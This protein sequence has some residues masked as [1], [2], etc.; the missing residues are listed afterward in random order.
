MEI[1]LHPSTG[2]LEMRLNGR[3]DAAWADYVSETLEDAVRAGSHQITLDF[4]QVSYIS[5][6]GIGVLLKHYNRLK[7]VQGTLV[8]VRPSASTLAVIK[9]SGLTEY[10]LARDATTGSAA[11]TPAKVPVRTAE[12]GGASFEIYAQV[13]GATFACDFIGDPAAFVRGGFSERDCRPLDLPD[14]S[15][16]VGLGAFG[17]NFTDCQPRF[18]E[19]AAAGGCAVTLPTSEQGVPDYVVTQGKLVPQVKALYA[20]AARGHFASML[21]FDEKADESGLVRL[22][23]LVDSALE[24]TSAEAG[25]FAIV[26]ESAGVVGAS[27]RRSPAAGPATGS[28]LDFPGVRDWLSFTTERSGERQ[29]VFIVGVAARRSSAQAAA[30]LR[31]L[32]PGSSLQGHFHAVVFPYRPVQ[33]GELRLS[34]TATDLLTASAPQTVRHLMTD[35]RPIEG[36]GETEL[37]RGACWTGPI[38]G[39]GAP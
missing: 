34:K 22:S 4:A 10:L 8:V 14:G 19:F 33:R 6:L 21:R 39:W 2:M 23:Q 38:A 20:I 7:A 35:S 26:A 1:T 16:A 12:H 29:L 3:F 18:G 5:S 27:L 36:V 9:A 28:P 24:L 32:A 31:P 13:P 37:V 25:C 11:A 17:E 15:V 30:F